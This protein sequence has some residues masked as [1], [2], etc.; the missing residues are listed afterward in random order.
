M[1]FA[2]TKDYLAVLGH[3]KAANYDAV[4]DHKYMPAG[5]FAL[6]LTPN[7][8][9][10]L[11]KLVKDSKFA[12]LKLNIIGEGYFLTLRL[13]SKLGINQCTVGISNIPPH[14]T[15]EDIRYIFDGYKLACNGKPIH[16]ISNPSSSTAHEVTKASESLYDSH[17]QTQYFIT[18]AS[19]GEAN[20]AI[21]E[22]LFTIVGG[23]EM[24]LISYCNAFPHA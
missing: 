8:A 5:K 6:S 17:S 16:A 12:N 10:E 24:Q 13:A 22:K 7:Q 4:L 15:V 19:V 23:K 3:I 1:P 11:F 18:F 14:I 20:R 21:Y 2:S 9:S